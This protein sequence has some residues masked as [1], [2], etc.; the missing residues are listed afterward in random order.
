MTGKSPWQAS[1]LK[2]G[3]QSRLL[4]QLLP[5]CL[6]PSCLQGSSLRSSNY[7][8]STKLNYFHH[9]PPHPCI[10]SSK[11]DSDL[12]FAHLFSLAH[13]L[14]YWARFLAPPHLILASHVFLFFLVHFCW[15]AILGF[16]C[17]F[18]AS[19]SHW[20]QLGGSSGIS[21]WSL[22]FLGFPSLH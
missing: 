18:L 1:V 15:K 10:P 8:S 7:S 3:P 19:L 6:H 12:V 17:G 9:G 22:L 13:R 21:C 4:Q 20:A 14:V 16:N 5:W 2:P 11:P